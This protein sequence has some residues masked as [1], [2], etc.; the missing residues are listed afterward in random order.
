[1]DGRTS[2]D[3]AVRFDWKGREGKE[4]GSSVLF[5]VLVFSKNYAHIHICSP[6]HGSK[7]VLF[8][9]ELELGI[10]SSSTTTTSSSLRPS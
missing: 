6:L 1:M 3:G 8:E 2:G 7:K 9:L 5:Y 4:D 10:S